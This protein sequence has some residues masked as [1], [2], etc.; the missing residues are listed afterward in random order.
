VLIHTCLAS[1]A[2]S[3]P[4]PNAT[5]Q[6]VAIQMGLRLV[7][8]DGLRITRLQRWV[9]RCHAC[10]GVSRDTAR[11]FCARCGNATL[12]R[13]S[14]SVD[15]QG[16][17][18]VGVRKRF[19]LRGTRYSLPA[20]KGG[21]YAVNPVL[22]EDQLAMKRLPSKGN[23]GGGDDVDVFAAEFGHDTVFERPDA[24]AAPSLLRAGTAPVVGRMRNPNARRHV[25]T[26]RRK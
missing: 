3:C 15:A 13:V 7:A 9:L 1:H 21:R 14:L 5:S 25:M 12:Q 18:H 8:P 10:G 19:N 16:V 24:G 20:P 6:N 17:E 22:R 23:R 4:D 2:Y 11:H 26:N